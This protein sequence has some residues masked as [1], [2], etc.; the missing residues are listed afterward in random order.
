MLNDP[1]VIVALDYENEAKALEFVA[2]VD[3]KLCKLKVGK[4][5]FTAAGPQ[6]V[7]KLVQKDFKVFLDL[8]F[9]DIPVTVTKACLA[10]ASLGVWMVN[11]HALGSKAMMEMAANEL[12]K[13]D[14]RPLLIAVTVLTSMNEEQLNLVGIEQKVPDEVLRLAT[15]AHDCGLDGVVASAQEAKLITSHLGSEFLKVTPGIRPQGSV[16][17]DQKRVMTPKE[18][19]ENG[20]SYLVIGRPITQALDP[21]ETLISINESLN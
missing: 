21:I 6:F 2:K 1:K 20:A 5:L 15:L 13:L 9:H 4:E 17:N 16:L 3:P 11:V 19:L 12:A 14:K 7:E 8:K 18:A 10:A